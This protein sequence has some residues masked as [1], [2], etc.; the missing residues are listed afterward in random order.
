[1]SENS[2]GYNKVKLK[3]LL[4]KKILSESEYVH[5]LVLIRKEL[6]ILKDNNSTDYSKFDHLKLFCDWTLHMVIDRS[7]TGSF[8]IESINKTL[9]D[10]KHSRTEDVIKKVSSSL[11]R[12]FSDQM[13]NFLEKNSLPTDIVDDDRYWRDL[14]R[15]ILEIISQ[16]P[17]ILKPK[18]EA[19]VKGAPLKEGMWAREVSIVKINFDKLAGKASISDKETYCLM[20]LTSDSTKLVIPI[21]PVIKS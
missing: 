5:V 21:T 19:N 11:I 13:K 15:N 17:V 8:L 7:A 3:L 1:M 14:L 20:V 6:E 9:N 2:M 4:Q 12:K 16:N 18:H 10:V